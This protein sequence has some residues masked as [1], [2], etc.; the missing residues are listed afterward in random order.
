MEI[1]YKIVF[2]RPSILLIGRTST[3]CMHADARATHCQALHRRPGTRKYSDTLDKQG[4]KGAHVRRRVERMRRH[5]QCPTEVP[6]LAMQWQQWPQR[7]LCAADVHF[8]L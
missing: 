7:S 8:L 4:K 6:L 5:T 2:N 1:R 3:Q